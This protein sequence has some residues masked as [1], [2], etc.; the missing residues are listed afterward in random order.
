MI[1]LL[2]ILVAVV[3]VLSNDP[4]DVEDYLF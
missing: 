3:I 1:A 4:G 2:A